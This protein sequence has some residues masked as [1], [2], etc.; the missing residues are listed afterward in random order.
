MTAVRT[1]NALVASIFLCLASVS[2]GAQTLKVAIEAEPEGLDPLLHH[3]ASGKLVSQHVGEAL[4]GYRADLSIAP[5]LAERIDV[6][7]DGRTYRFPL[8]VG[9]QFHNGAAVT[10]AD[11]AWVFNEYYLDPERKWECLPFYDGTGTTEERTAGVRVRDVRAVDRRTVEFRLEE[12]S[13]LFLHRLADTSCVPL[14]F[15][16]AS[17][18][19]DGKLRALI[20][21]G[22]FRMGE[23]RRGESVRVDRFEGYRPGAGKRDGYGGA[24]EALVQAIEFVVVPKSEWVPSLEAGTVHVLPDVE[25]AQYAAARDTKGVESI[26]TPLTS[27]YDLLI[28]TADPLLSDKRIR[29]AIAHA[30]DLDY[31]AAVVTQGRGRGNPSVIALGADFHTKA[32]DGRRPLDPARARELLREAGYKGAPLTLQTSRDAYPWLYDAAVVVHSMLRA[33]GLNVE[34]QVIPWKQQ[35]DT[36]YRGGSFQLNLFLFGGR[37]SPTLAYGKFIGPKATLARFQWDDAEAFAL[38]QK[39]EDATTRETLQ[40]AY[41]ELHRRMVEDVP[42]L[43]LFNDERFDLIAAGVRGYEPTRFMRVPLWGVSLEP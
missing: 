24:R 1:A 4:V 35:L 32:H 26:V 6:S 7:T 33:V 23:W 17:L 34:L 37:N 18:G 25:Y 15:H 16:R 20:G 28:Q 5:V 31:V 19:A 11:V 12:P 41:D 39:A 43:P 29:Q 2:V 9:A 42:T 30:I 3:H 14:V 38:V 27:W 8:R 22:P 21:T 10:A 40:A 13:S 36:H